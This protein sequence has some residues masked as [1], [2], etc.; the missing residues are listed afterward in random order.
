VTSAQRLN[1]RERW[2]VGLWIVL[3]VALWN[4][5]YD[6][7][8]GVGI[9]EYLFRSVLHEAGRGP[10]VSIPAVLEPF[11]FDAL[12]VSTFWA[13]LVMLAGLITIRVL[14]RVDAG[15][16]PPASTKTDSAR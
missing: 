2:L 16:P 11:L 6:M 1:T 15:A 13:S 4:G 14:R 12:W 5:V 9:K 8:L 10:Q 3:A 7:T